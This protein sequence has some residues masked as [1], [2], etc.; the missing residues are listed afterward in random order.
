MPTGNY[1][2]L[3]AFFLFAFTLTTETPYCNT[4]WRYLDVFSL[5]FFKSQ[6]KKRANNL[7][8]KKSPYTLPYI[9]FPLAE[10]VALH[11]NREWLLWVSRWR[12]M[13][14]WL[15]S[16]MEKSAWHI[17]SLSM[18][19][20]RL[21]FLLLLSFLLVGWNLVALFQ[22]RVK[23]LVHLN[24][25]LGGNNR[26]SKSKGLYTL[27]RYCVINWFIDIIYGRNRK[28][29]GHWESRAAK[30]GSLPGKSGA[31]ASTELALDY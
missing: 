18:N 21:L 17:S 20:I 30:I 29:G 8:E 14:L 31:L 6:K 15:P 26:L 9:T 5:I 24:S 11:T 13:S 23:C 10:S 2:T 16:S 22:G 25:F 3:R 28:Q 12:F 7:H 19:K 4:G 27:C 1:S